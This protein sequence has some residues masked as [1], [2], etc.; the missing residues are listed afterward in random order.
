MPEGELSQQS[1]D[2]RG[3]VHAAEKGLHPSGTHQVEVINAVCT[4]T[5]AGVTVVSFGD[6]LA[7]PDLIVSGHVIPQV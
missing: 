2:G 1:S 6:G 5:H 4:D 3:C 7:D